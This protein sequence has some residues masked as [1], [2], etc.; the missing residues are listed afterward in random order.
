M[1]AN[2]RLGAVALSTIIVL[3]MAVAGAVVPV[4]QA[5]NT[6]TPTATPTATPTDTPTATSTPTSTGTPTPTDTPTDSPTPTSTDTGTDTPTATATE[7]ATPTATEQS[8]ESKP[9]KLT[10]AVADRLDQTGPQTQSTGSTTMT[11]RL[12]A[13]PGK[14]SDAA[15]L[16]RSN[17]GEIRSR[18]GDA[19]V[20]ELP[21][22][23]VRTVA[24]NPAIEY[25]QRPERPQIT[26]GAVTSEGIFNMSA[27]EVHADGEDGSGT[28]VAVIDLDSSIPGTSGGFDAANSEISSNVVETRDMTNGGAFVNQPNRHGT[29]VAE[30]VVDTAPNVS[31]ILLEIESATEFQN[32]INYSEKADV[33]VASLGYYTGPFDGSGDLSTE[34]T[35]ARQ[36]GT[37]TFISAGNEGDGNHLNVTWND[38]DNN[39]VLNFSGSD[40]RLNITPPIGSTLSSSARIYVSWNDYPNSNEDY[41]IYLHNATDAIVANSRNPQDGNQAPQEV[42]S[43]SS[44]VQCPCS[45]N[46][47][48]YDAT[49]TADFNIFTNTGTF[50][51][52]TSARSLTRP[53]TSEDAVTVGAINYKDLLLADYSSRGPTVDGRRGVDV[54]APAGV[55]TDAYGT[56]GFSGTSAAA[57]HAAGVGA[58]LRANNSSLT[59]DYMEEIMIRNADQ[60]DPAHDSPDPNNRTGYG[61]IDA[62]EALT[63]MQDRADAKYPLPERW[64]TSVG[65]SSLTSPTVTLSSIYV[66]SDDTNVYSIRRDN[67]SERWSYST[68]G[69]IHS[70]PAVYN[71]T[72]FLGSDD[73]NLYALNETDG[74]ERWNVSL[75]GPVRSSPAVNNSTV[76]VGSDAGNL[77]AVNETNGAI[78]WNVTTGG[79]VRSSPVVNNST[80]YVGSDDGRLYAVNDTTGTVSWRADAG[81]QIRTTPEPAPVKTGRIYV[82]S[83]AAALHSINATTGSFHWNFTPPTGVVRSSPA[84]AD[85]EDTVIF[86]SDDGTI[87]AVEALFGSQEW[88]YSTGSA[89]RSSPAI[90]TRQYL[91]NSETTAYVGSDD[92]TLRAR[93]VPSGKEQGS[94]DSGD[95]ISTSPAV[96]HLNAYFTNDGGTMYAINLSAYLT[97]VTSPPSPGGGGG[98]GGGGG[99]GGASS[100]SPPAITVHYQ[101]SSTVLSID[102]PKPGHDFTSTFV[103]QTPSAGG[104]SLHGLSGTLTSRHDFDVDVRLFEKR[105][106]TGVDTA[107][108]TGPSL[109]Y[110]QVDH[111]GNT[112]NNAGFTFDVSKQA[113]RQKGIH[114]LDVVVYRFDGVEWQSFDPYPQD[115]EGNDVTYE[116]KTS[117]SF[118]NWAIGGSGTST[119]TPT[120]TPT[121]T[122]EPTPT[123]IPEDTETPTVAEPAQQRE[124]PTELPATPTTTPTLPPTTGGSPTGNESATTS[125]GG[126][127]FGI[128]LALLALSLTGAFLARRQHDR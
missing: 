104:V 105:S 8:T 91:F 86:G 81:A 35:E 123:A 37:P 107:L 46:I 114:P 121:P 71:D 19:V 34:I 51:Y 127:G 83:D 30:V 128:V 111:S 99:V 120:L 2:N 112:I 29:A 33:T 76:Y 59:S 126:P 58:L 109:T 47:T 17:G 4:T 15:A 31:L 64:N 63:F 87:Y 108:P 11:V 93:Y 52:N 73:G 42:V 125:T 118:S 9:T 6:P 106:E 101:D 1:S 80:V 75:G 74:S 55:S 50:E 27:D 100:T 113:L 16:A 21:V 110:L 61:L 44:F 26:A 79:V 20:V 38:P 22:N 95:P 13:A 53:A 32:A 77:T 57:P 70:Q 18:A 85:A 122:L 67:G 54:V 36:N 28:T 97:R 3:S 56:D 116:V 115:T 39:G 124:T 68:G 66:G 10:S 92:G 43:P 5:G 69:A 12:N 103:D 78:E 25:V 24:K 49:G 119:A 89:V 94:F 62:M 72:V 23:A 40:E 82:G 60:T 14:G 65:G 7:T 48:E 84:Y 45:L 102:N 90:D 117:S 88:T 41:D 98:G 96:R